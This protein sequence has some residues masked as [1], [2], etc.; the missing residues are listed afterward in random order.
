[1]I[2]TI[3]AI[4]IGLPVIALV[5]GAL[6][7]GPWLIG[8]KCVDEVDSRVMVWSAGAIVLFVIVVLLVISWFVG[9]RLLQWSAR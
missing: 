4:L 6:V 8:R 2:A 9:S 3:E 1:M 5:V 7:F